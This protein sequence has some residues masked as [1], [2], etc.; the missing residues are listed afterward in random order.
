VTDRLCE[1]CRA[2]VG[3]AVVRLLEGGS[4]T[5]AASSTNGARPAARLPEILSAPEPAAE[6]VVTVTAPQVQKL[7]ALRRVYEGDLRRR[8]DSRDA[9]LKRRSGSWAATK[10]SRPGFAG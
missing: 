4:T 6:R 8:P 10:T 9:E 7:V 2:V 1:D 5:S 3:R